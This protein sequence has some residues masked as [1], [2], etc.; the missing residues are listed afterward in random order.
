MIKI[1]VV[2]FSLLIS[3]SFTFAQDKKEV[4]LQEMVVTETKLP[5]TPNEI[6]HKIDVISRDELDNI[7][8][9]NRNLSEAFRYLPGVFINPLSRNDANWGTYGG[10]GPKYNSYLLDGLPIDSF[11]DPMSLDDIYI[12]RAEVHRGP[13][14]V[15]YPN[16]M[17]MDFAGNQSA[18]AGISNLITK[19]RISSPQSRI[20]L[21]YGSFNTVYTRLYHE[22][23]KGDFHYLLGGLYEQ[24]D[25]KNYGT[26]PSWLNMID[27]PEYKKAKLFFKTTYFISSDSKIS[28]FAHHTEHRGDTGRPNRQYSHQYDI[29]NAI[30]ENKLSPV[31]NLSAKAG[32]RY[33]NRGW[34]EDNYPTNLSLREKDGVRQRIFPFDIALN[35]KHLN[36]SVLTFGAD[37][38][39]SDYTTHA[40]I[41]GIKTYGNDAKADNYGIYLQEKLIIDKWV[42][43]LGGRF[44]YTKHHYDLI[45]GVIPEITSKSWSK[46]LWTAGVRYNLSD[47]IAIYSNAG[48]SFLAPSAKSI[49]GTIRLSDKFVAGRNGQL[50]NPNLK[51]E[52]GYGYDLGLELIPL[53]D[54]LIGFRGF[55]NIVDDAIVENTISR[56]P[57]QTQS[58]NAGKAKSYGVEMEL[59]HQLNKSVSW[60]TNATLTT[61]KIKNPYDTDQDNS[62]V[63]F[64]PKMIAN[65]GGT[66]RLPYD[67]VISPYLQYV[68]SYYDSTSKT[69][70]KEFGKYATI[71]ANLQKP[72]IKTSQYIANLIVEVN[73]I[74][75]E[76]YEMPWQFQ[77]V[78]FNLMAR[79]EMRF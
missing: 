9:P 4:T 20:T 33:Y 31:V 61:T 58:V 71:N 52:N 3:A 70:R 75:N 11:V 27:D 51:P 49:G 63:P 55:Y 12:Q 8:L 77:D 36:N 41:G 68:G 18:L 44:N 1:F 34:D 28:L 39:F 24:S 73:N 25:Y 40:E 14:A 48:S 43:R 21:G 45:G 26:N 47:T 37:G 54:M 16:Y 53:K 74:T 60:F 15:L 7:N 57:S 2:V 78:G 59:Q 66:F 30:Y 17:T 5:Q 67:F 13:A 32:F 10:L 65:L 19:E 42:L 46:V 56:D 22:G 79:I 72:L 23:F 6:T 50:P 76:K 62:N 64:A 29:V 35:Y 69:G 38:Q